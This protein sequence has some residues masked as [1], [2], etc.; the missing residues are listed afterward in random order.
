MPGQSVP[1]R[2]FKTMIERVVKDAA[3]NATA[4]GSA[5]KITTGQVQQVL[6]NNRVVVDGVT[7]PV[8]GDAS[9]MAEGQ[10][11]GVAWS[12][13]KPTAVVFHHAQSAQFVPTLGSTSG[14]VEEL[15]LAPPS[16]GGSVT[17]WF[18]NFGQVTELTYS[19]PPGRKISA[20]WTGTGK[21]IKWGVN[22][23]VFA[24][25]EGNSGQERIHVY[26]LNRPST[27]KILGTS[28]VKVKEKLGS[29]VLSSIGP[30]AI[31]NVAIHLKRDSVEPYVEL[32]WQ[33]VGP[34]GD[35]SAIFTPDHIQ[36]HRD[37]G[38][39]EN[40]ADVDRSLTIN[41]T[42]ATSI[43]FTN[44]APIAASEIVVPSG[45][46]PSSFGAALG[47]W[48]VDE[49]NHPIYAVQITFNDFGLWQGNSTSGLVGSYHLMG[50]GT[51]TNIGLCF[52]PLCPGVVDNIGVQDFMDHGNASGVVSTH[53]YEK[54]VV[55]I[56]AATGTVKS[57]TLGD[58]VTLQ[59]EETSNGVSPYR[60]VHN[61]NMPSPAD[62]CGTPNNGGPGGWRTSPPALPIGLTQSLGDMGDLALIRCEASL[63]DQT[64]PYDL[65]M[66]NDP[67]PSTPTRVATTRIDSNQI[68]YDRE[69]GDFFG[70]NCSF[71]IAQE[72]LAKI[73]WDFHVC[74]V[75]RRYDVNVTMTPFLASTSLR[76][77]V[78]VIREAKHPDG[79]SQANYSGDEHQ[80]G[81]FII[82]SDGSAVGT[83]RG[84]TSGGVT[85]VPRMTFVTANDRHAIWKEATPSGSSDIPWFISDYLTGNLLQAGT[86]EPANLKLLSPDL[87]YATSESDPKQLYFVKGWDR[88]TL[89][90][91]ADFNDGNSKFPKKD[92][93]LQSIGALMK[94]KSD[95][96]PG[97]NPDYHVIV[98]TL[99]LPSRYRDATT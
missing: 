97:E 69:W 75:K 96:S 22:K 12:D 26:R 80:Y 82:N 64:L 24:V 44:G 86:K 54:H 15:F 40:V 98:D 56:D 1:G 32:F 2:R 5:Q 89:A 67:T 59:L 13:G 87:L 92:G 66:G 45:L 29:Y 78:E 74:D 46:P 17:G 27:T 25:L 63:F 47:D 33:P 34:A 11:V 62:Q 38:T 79:G 99:L 70:A 51:L 68:G 55:L 85:T 19:D 81:A 18:R 21:R 91:D 41:I 88:D 23:D 9:G 28:G 16:G 58:N 31:C 52:I 76:W 48:G 37:P 36:F 65:P 8:T 14:V 6:P 73:D 7:L 94:L 95:V 30:L 60:F 39:N 10:R 77:F 83:A 43:T 3:V 90:F 93:A 61:F 57:K 35:G 84:F 50:E 53:I 20:D 49:N 72:R 71:F 42:G 4:A